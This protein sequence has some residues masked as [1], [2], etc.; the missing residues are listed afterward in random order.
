MMKK[1]KTSA[2]TLNNLL[3]NISLAAEI[4]M[5]EVEGPLN[6]KQKSYV[7]MILEE[8]KK[9]KEAIQKLD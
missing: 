9:M 2:H 4:L 3:A 6:A 1:T 8:G 7:K 5:Q